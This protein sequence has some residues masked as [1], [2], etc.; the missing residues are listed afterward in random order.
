MS[1]LRVA[2]AGC[3]GRMGQALVRLIPADPSLQL[4][5]ALTAPDD[6]LVGRDAGRVVGLDDLHV[7]VATTVIEACDVVI[8]FT[9]PAGCEHWARWCAEHRTPLVSGTTGLGE[10]EQAALRAAAGSVPVVWAPNMSVGVNLLLE[11]VAD[12]AAKLGEDWDV[13]ICET[14]H[15]QKVDAP[16]GTAR[17]LLDAVCRGRGRDS[18]AVAVHGRVGDGGPRPAGQVG[19]HALR[20]GMIVGEHEVHF[21]SDAES[22]TLRHRA[23]TRETFAAGAL[24]AARWLIGRP[25]GLYSMRDVLFA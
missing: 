24:R 2:V 6:P 4:V 15:R 21:T 11:L 22:V 5:A 25:P 3:S 18:A 20:M 12:L 14:H 19:V 1:A 23:F 8:E 16:S 17:A 10:A 13:E 7:S 9:T